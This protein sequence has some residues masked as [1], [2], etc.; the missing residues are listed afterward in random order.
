M[1]SLFHCLSGGLVG[2]DITWQRCGVHGISYVWWHAS[3]HGFM[4]GMFS[5]FI[6]VHGNIGRV[7]PWW[8]SLCDGTASMVF[9][10]THSVEVP[11]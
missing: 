1:V 10:Q 6:I 5:I 2:V 7:D 8:I 11:H 9:G 4:C 3:L